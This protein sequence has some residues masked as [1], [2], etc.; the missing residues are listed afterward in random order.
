LYLADSGKNDREIAQALKISAT[1]VHNVR[2]RFFHTRY[3]AGLTESP[4]PGQPRR[5]TPVTAAKIS[6]LVRTTPP[7]GHNHWTLHL[8][9]DRAV[10]LD[11]VDAISHE[12]V[13]KL[14]Q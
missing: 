1:T 9:A 3:T 7:A 8:L 2:K 5:L 10:K 14:L 6:G 11:L 13:R 4:R 12:S